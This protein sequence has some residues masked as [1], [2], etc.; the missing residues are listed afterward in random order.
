MSKMKEI[1][2]DIENIF[3]SLEN[4]NEICYELDIDEQDDVYYRPYDVKAIVDRGSNMNGQDIEF[5]Q[6]AE[7]Q[8]NLAKCNILCYNG[9]ISYGDNFFY[10]C[11]VVFNT[12][13]D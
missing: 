4:Y 5:I 8:W 7:V 10:V 6:K 1:H 11:V 9:S 12:N 3:G 2:I 13:V